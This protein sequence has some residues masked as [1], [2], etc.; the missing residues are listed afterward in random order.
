MT[1]VILKD[2]SADLD[3]TF[4]WSDFLT[5]AEV[6]SSSAWDATPTGLTIDNKTKDNTT[7]TCYLAGGTIGQV[8]RVVNTI[9]TNAAAP[10]TEDRTLT[11]RIGN[12]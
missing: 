2:P 10:R 6:I 7:A 9:V 4:D 1:L 3:Y 5:G 11:V 12:K 8:F